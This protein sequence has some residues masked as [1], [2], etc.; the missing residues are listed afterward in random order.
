M[1]RKKAQPGSLP[2]AGAELKKMQDE[3]VS[4]YIFTFELLRQYPNI[5]SYLIK[6]P[7]KKSFGDTISE[8]LGSKKK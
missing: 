4:Q 3:H 5:R 8:L 6:Q 2:P 7:L 1:K